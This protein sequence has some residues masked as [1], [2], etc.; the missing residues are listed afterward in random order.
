MS[1]RAVVH[2]S[3]TSEWMEFKNPIEIIETSKTDEILCS[4]ERVDKYAKE[5]KKYAVGFISY[6]ASIAFDSAM[7]V[8]TSH[9]H[10]M[11]LLWFAVFD[12]YKTIK[13]PRTEKTNNHFSDWSSTVSKNQYESAI[14]SVKDYIKAGETYQVNYTFRQHA[15]FHGD[16]WKLFCEL[17]NSQRSIYCAFIETDEF[18]L[19]SASPE[20]FF[21]LK[22][23]LIVSKPMKGTSPRGN[24]LE[25]DNERKDWL[26]HSQKNRSENI[27]IVDMIRN[28]IGR[29]ASAGSVMIPK[30]YEVEKYPTVWQMTSTVQAYT[31]KSIPDIMKALFPCASITGA[32]KVRT[33]E[34]IAELENTPRGIYTGSVGFIAPDNSAQFNVAIRSVV[35]DKKTSLAEYGVGGGI[36]WDS[37]HDDE[38]EECLI[39]TKFLSAPIPDFSLIESILWTPDEG[40]FLLDYHLKRMA[41]SAEYF[42]YKWFVD[43][44][45]GI[46]QSA[47]SHFA[48]VPQKVRVLSDIQGEITLENVPVGELKTEIKVAVAYENV[49]R[50]NPF[51]Y[52]KTTNRKI[53]ENI[54]SRY[55]KCDEVILYNEDGE[56]TEGI[57]SN[58]VMK[59]GNC[60][61]T[62]PVSCGLLGGTF[63][64]HL[65]DRGKIKEKV[66]TIDEI[67]S[68]EEVY[69]INSVR[70]FRKAS[71]IVQK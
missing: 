4:L 14:S 30:Q 16:P 28:D 63:R 52:H 40:Y 38:Y 19:C 69:L 53:Y 31:N 26:Y 33:M 23:G 11:P 13:F 5:H 66:I 10:K 65:L 68:A 45:K 46:L 57:S 49:R 71:F 43:R 61:F 7:S 51:L 27:M 20:L 58:I 48:S 34:I 1:L 62:P 15:E 18:A 41:R 6:D 25:E 70:K 29:V 56:I 50:N 64:Q 67:K 32:P 55:A 21:T 3:F 59:T 24:T 39:K 37:T 54:K 17:S 35:I 9:K 22:N 60:L 42:D 47:I 2:N 12:S 44:V 36:V 8:R